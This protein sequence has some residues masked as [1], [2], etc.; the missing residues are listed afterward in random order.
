LTALTA[1]AFAGFMCFASPFEI[2]VVV[3]LAL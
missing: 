3:F 1:E 2:W